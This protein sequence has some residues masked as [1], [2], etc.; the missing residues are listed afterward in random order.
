[1]PLFRRKPQGVPIDPTAGDPRAARLIEAVR[2][3]DPHAVRAALDVPLDAA[4]RERLLSIMT[5]VEGHPEVFDAWVDVEP[6]SQLALLARGA[7]GVSFAWQARGADRAERVEEDAWEVFFDRLRV[8]AEDLWRAAELDPADPV[9][10]TNLLISGRGLQV[11]K[12]E[13]RMRYE[14]L[15]QRAPWLLEAQLQTLHFLCKKWFGSDEESLAFARNVDRDAPTGSSARA[16]VPMAHI[17]LWLDLHDREGGGDPDAYK[18]RTDVRDEI[19]AAAERSVFADG[20]EDDLRT[21]PA[22]N[23]FA[24]GLGMFGDEEGARALVQRLGTRRTEFPWAYYV[25]PDTVYGALL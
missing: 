3:D 21:V 4:E 22:L 16:V 11:P 6:D 23:A 9:P 17:E 20:F 10:W 13:E 15:Q 12:E 18:Q 19:R 8:A 5:A 1:M 7:Y 14:E 25:D 24:M 2:S